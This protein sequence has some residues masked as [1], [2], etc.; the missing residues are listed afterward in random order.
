MGRGAMV[1]R[2]GRETA[3]K[4]QKCKLDGASQAVYS[5][6]SARSAGWQ[7]SASRQMCD[8]NSAVSKSCSSS[9]WPA[10]EVGHHCLSLQPGCT[11]VT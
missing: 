11:P 2:G 4:R 6:K 8:F 1:G 3:E 9:F 7:S 10:N 5:P